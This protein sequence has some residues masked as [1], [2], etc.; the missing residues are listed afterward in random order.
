MAFLVGFGI[1]E[2]KSP[3]M[4]SVK[5]LI[6][7]IADAR[8]GWDLHPDTAHGWAREFMDWYN[9]RNRET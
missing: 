6:L 9:Q 7:D 4:A 5:E 8:R 3:D 2:L 1:T